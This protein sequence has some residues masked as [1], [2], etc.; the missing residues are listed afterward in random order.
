[1]PTPLLTTNIFNTYQQDLQWQPS[2]CSD[3]CMPYCCLMHLSQQASPSLSSSF[4]TLSSPRLNQT[5]NPV[6]PICPHA[7]STKAAGT[8]TVRFD[9]TSSPDQSKGA[10]AAAA[11]AAKDPN[12]GRTATTYY[13]ADDE[14]AGLPDISGGV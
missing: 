11:A 12:M 5:N 3:M 13:D 8:H 7:V 2:S 4:H 14:E 1:M 6:I 10:A 9:T